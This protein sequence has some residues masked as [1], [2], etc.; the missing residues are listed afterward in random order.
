MTKKDPCRLLKHN[1]TLKPK[2]LQKIQCDEEEET[3]SP[4]EALGDVLSPSMLGPSSGSGEEKTQ[5][6]KSVTHDRKASEN[7]FAVLSEVALADEECCLSRCQESNNNPVTLHAGAALGDPGRFL[8]HTCA[9]AH[10]R[11]SYSRLSFWVLAA[12]SC[13]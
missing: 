3:D 7:E 5:Q 12:S 13:G 9:H 4:M 2:A 11:R 10:T 6:R 1:F 8:F